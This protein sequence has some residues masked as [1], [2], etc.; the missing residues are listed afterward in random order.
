MAA[1]TRPSRLRDVVA[2]LTESSLV[3]IDANLNSLSIHRIV[4]RF[5]LEGL[6][7]DA[8]AATTA[9]NSA[10]SLL[11]AR[12]PEKDA[13]RVPAREELAKSDPLVDYIVQV[14]RSCTCLDEFIQPSH[15]LAVLLLDGCGH[16]LRLGY[17]DSIREVVDFALVVLNRLDVG[18]G[19]Q[20]LMKA[21]RLRDVAN[22]WI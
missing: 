8:D 17:L 1:L 12:V 9:F 11:R 15:E 13:L 10:F 22:D 20:L 7:Q 19:D 5:V 2:E 6:K 14:V 18:S 3:Q 21:A 4:Q 16:M